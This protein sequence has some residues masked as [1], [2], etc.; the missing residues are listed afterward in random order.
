MIIAFK[1]ILFITFFFI[2]TN[3]YSKEYDLIYNFSGSF[4]KNEMIFL[5]NSRLTHNVYEA[6]W[7]DNYGNYGTSYCLTSIKNESKKI[8]IKLD[9]YC[10]LKDQEGNI[11]TQYNGRTGNELNAGSGKAKFIEGQKKW[12]F[13]I[14][15][16]CLYSIKYLENR[17]FSIRKCKITKDMH[18]KLLNQ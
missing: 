12:K 5:D 1:N 16:E 6:E 9:S 2:L 13:L 7:T 10:R 8:I 11:F 15:A 3:S 4:E 18:Y 17:T 14:G